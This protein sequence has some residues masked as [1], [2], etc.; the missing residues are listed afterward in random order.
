MRSWQDE[1]SYNFQELER[2]QGNMQPQACPLFNS[3][4]RYSR[5]SKC[6]YFF[7]SLQMM[8]SNQCLQH[9]VQA[10]L[11]FFTL[12]SA[13]MLSLVWGSFDRNWEHNSRSDAFFNP[14]RIKSMSDW[15]I[16]KN[17]Y[18]KTSFSTPSA[19]TE[20][21]GTRWVLPALPGLFQ[22]TAC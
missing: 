9:E 20:W 11:A 16:P 17:R 12:V 14:Q 7:C 6:C 8:Q 18:I 10:Q 1:A 4:S 22:W 3:T 5:N 21:M 15:R 19:W 2:S 13:Y